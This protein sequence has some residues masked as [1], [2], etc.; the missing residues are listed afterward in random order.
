MFLAQ[1]EGQI[2]DINLINLT[3]RNCT[4]NGVFINGSDNVNIICC[5]FN[6]TGSNVVPGPKLVHNLLLTRCIGINVKDSRLVTSPYGSGIALAHCRDAK[7]DNC[8]VARNG[9]YGI[10]VSESENVSV[11]G[12]LIEA[13]DRSGIM[14]EFLFK[15]SE[16]ITV[17]NNL[18]QYNNGYGVESYSARKINVLNNNYAGNGNTDTQQK[19]SEDKFII[20]Q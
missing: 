5:D 16:N 3:V 17:T 4:Y 15:G 19:I 1:K 13:N 11:T 8:E 20:M 18:I 7:I 10:L 14:F 2:K 6:E 9:Y 12:S